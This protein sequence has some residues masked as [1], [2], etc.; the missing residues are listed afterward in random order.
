MENRAKL[1]SRLLQHGDRGSAQLRTDLKCHGWKALGDQFS[2]EELETSRTLLQQW[3]S[4]GIH[5]ISCLD[6]DY[7][8]NLLSLKDHPLS[9]FIQGDWRNQ[10]GLSVAVVGTRQPSPQGLARTRRLTTALARAGVSIVSGLARGIDTQA[11]QAALAAG[12]RTLAVL[13]TG[14]DHCYPPENFS[15][16][17]EI[18]RT[19]AV[20]SQFLP[21]F[22]GSRYSFPMRNRVIAGISRL[23][24]VVEANQGSGA[25]DEARA[26]LRIGR[27]LFLLRSLVEQQDWAEKLS[28]REDVQVLD[29]VDQILAHL[30]QE[31]DRPQR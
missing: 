31:A 1:L 6:A 20:I 17:R 29:H 8:E 16:Q 18:A 26:C 19:G 21:Q 22:G 10:D 7:P 23:S 3:R 11:H 5:L 15:L 12:G 24:V 2:A 9:L 4:R 14:H 13:G 25:E 30:S 28:H 27:P